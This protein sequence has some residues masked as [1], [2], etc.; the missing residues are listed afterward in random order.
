MSFGN[1]KDVSCWNCH[2]YQIEKCNEYMTVNSDTVY[3]P[4]PQ[5]D[6]FAM[7]SRDFSWHVGHFIRN[8]CHKC[9]NKVIEI[10]GFLRCKLSRLHLSMKTS[11]PTFRL[12]PKAKMIGRMSRIMRTRGHHRSALLYP[13][14]WDN[15]LLLC[16]FYVQRKTEKCI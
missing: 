3:W 9:S 6:H 14:L 5:T 1:Y 8:S 15:I 4:R 16:P 11:N 12:R 10:Y 2:N 13:K 7:H